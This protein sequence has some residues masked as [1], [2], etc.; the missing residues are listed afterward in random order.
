M[1][2]ALGALVVPATASAAAPKQL[3]DLKVT[4]VVLD[5]VGKPA[6]IVVSRDGRATAFGVRVTVANIGNASAGRSRME[7]GADSRNR[8]LDLDSVEVRALKPGQ[9]QTNGFD[10]HDVQFPLGNLEIHA[11]ADAGKQVRSRVP[12][13]SRTPRRRGSRTSR[14]TGTSR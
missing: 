12:A 5:G 9:S 8:R 10:I 14:P 11:K 2:A 6:H 1:I 13:A 7:L 3:P 4:K